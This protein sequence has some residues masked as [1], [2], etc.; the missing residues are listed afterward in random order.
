[1]ATEFCQKCKRV[2]P[3]RVCDYDE[4]GECAETHVVEERIEAA[5]P[6][7]DNQ[8]SSAGQRRA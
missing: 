6:S 8:R 3:D 7:M 1:M 5:L 4:Q 2:H